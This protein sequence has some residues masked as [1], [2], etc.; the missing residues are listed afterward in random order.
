[1][2]N[3]ISEENLAF[4]IKYFHFYEKV[5]KHLEDVP[6]DETKAMFLKALEHRPG[7]KQYLGG[8]SYFWLELHKQSTKKPDGATKKLTHIASPTDL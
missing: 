8:P 3:S 7:V 5:R 6:G 2:I 1:M 4:I